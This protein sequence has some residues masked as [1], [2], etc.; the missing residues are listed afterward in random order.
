MESKR[1]RRSEDF[2]QEELEEEKGILLTVS[3]RRKGGGDVPGERRD[4][5]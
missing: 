5:W 4:R 2:E 1:G 3:A